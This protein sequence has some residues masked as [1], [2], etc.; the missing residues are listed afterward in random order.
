M[1]F[2]N[3]HD[4]IAC[5]IMFALLATTIKGY[6]HKRATGG[7]PHLLH[8]LAMQDQS[9]QDLDTQ[10]IANATLSS[11][12]GLPQVVSLLERLLSQN[13]QIAV[14]VSTFMATLTKGL[15]LTAGDCSDVA[16][17]GPY[18][19]GIYEITPWDD[20]GF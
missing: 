5:A 12:N 7:I 10:I 9:A 19:S 15:H 16:L 18:G 8:D 17:Q 2:G 13:Q 4:F 11:S 6:P 20:L 14:A 3:R 1:D